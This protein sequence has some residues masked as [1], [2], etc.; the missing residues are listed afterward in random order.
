MEL[1]VY[2]SPEEIVKDRLCTISDELY[3]SDLTPGLSN[4]KLKRFL[5]E[6]SRGF[7]PQ[8]KTEAMILGNAFHSYFLEPEKFQEEYHFLGSD[9]KGTWNKTIQKH[10]EEGILPSGKKFLREHDEDWIVA[11][12]RKA[13][14]HPVLAPL[15]SLNE[16]FVECALFFHDYEHNIDMKLKADIVDVKNKVII[17]LKSTKGIRS[18]EKDVKYDIKRLD[19]DMQAYIYTK[20]M[21][22][23]IGGH[24]KFY[25]V[26]CEK[27]PFGEI[28]VGEISDDLMGS[29]RNKYQKALENYEMALQARELGQPYFRNNG[30]IETW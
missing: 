28:A 30:E 29:G 8:N 17:D 21:G 13:I 20:A 10:V 9:Y 12:H 7:L 26:L 4:S 18:E 27:D 19:Y 11:A 23:A 16:V 5:N 1:D 2:N 22:Q 24:W 14:Q 15:K 25:I 6:P 3:Y